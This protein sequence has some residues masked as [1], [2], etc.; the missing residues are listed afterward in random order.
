MGRWAAVSPT[1]GDLTVVF[2][3]AS[4]AQDGSA[5]PFVETL[6]RELKCLALYVTNH[7]DSVL[8][9]RLFKSGEV[10]DNYCSS[11]TYFLD[12]W[13]S[14]DQKAPE[15]GDADILCNAFGDLSMREKVAE[16]LRYNVF[17]NE[18]SDRYAFEIDRH[19]DIVVSLGLPAI[20]VGYGYTYLADGEFPAGLLAD[21]LV[22]VEGQ[23]SA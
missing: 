19:R 13:T 2:D 1:Y 8:Y 16:M 21:E 6:S 20:A 3:R 10:V 22:L 12:E 5:Y 7:D 23:S 18:S 11:P 14:T 9:Y 4:E 17:G 15:G